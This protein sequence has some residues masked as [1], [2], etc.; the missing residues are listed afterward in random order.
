MVK[1]YALS[2]VSANSNELCAAIELK[3]DLAKMPINLCE[4]YAK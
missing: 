2:N 3:I 4:V 1:I